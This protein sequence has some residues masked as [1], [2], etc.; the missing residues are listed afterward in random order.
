MNYSV[1]IML[2]NDNVRLLNCTF[3]ETNQIYVY[4]CLDPSIKPGDYAVVEYGEKQQFSAV[5][6]VGE[7][8]AI[9]ITTDNGVRYKWIV[10]RIDVEAFKLLKAQEEAIVETIKSAALQRRRK[11]LRADLIDLK[12]ER[13]KALPLVH[14]SDTTKT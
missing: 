1:A 8:T 2:V 11:E 9:D 6:V 10:A 13:L 5:K 7:N 14:I 4:K 12:D 3:A